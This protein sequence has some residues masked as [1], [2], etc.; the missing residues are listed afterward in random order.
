[1][2]SFYVVGL[3]AAAL[4]IHGCKP[5]PQ[6]PAPVAPSQP[7]LPA[8]S[9]TPADTNYHAYLDFHFAG[10]ASLATNQH[11][12][13]L[14]AIAALPAVQAQGKQALDKFAANAPRLIGWQGKGT[15]DS[16]RLRPLLDDFLQYGGSFRWDQAPGEPPSWSVGVTLPTERAETWKKNLAAW[17]APGNPAAIKSLAPHNV[18]GWETTSETG[19]FRF[20]QRENSVALWFGRGAKESLEVLLAPLGKISRELPSDAWLDCRANAGGVARLNHFTRGLVS[21][22]I[23]SSTGTKPNME[24]VASTASPALELKLSCKDDH[25]RTHVSLKYGQPLD[26]GVSPWQIPTRT[27]QDPLLSFTAMQ[28]ASSHLQ[29]LFPWLGPQDFLPLAG[30]G[31]E[32]AQVF[33]WGQSDVPFQTYVAVSL[34]DTTNALMKLG[35]ELE[36]RWAETLKARSLGKLQRDEK[37]GQINWQG[38]L[39][40][41]V[42]FLAPA[43]DA[44][45]A[46][47]GIFPMSPAPKPMPPELAAQVTGRTNVVYYSWEITQGRLMQWKLLGQFLT[48]LKPVPV[49]APG[50]P[51]VPMPP[52]MPGMA[53]S[54]GA[55][56][57]DELGKELGNSVTEVTLASPTELMLTRKSHS[58]FTALEWL[59]ISHWLGGAEFPLLKMAGTNAPPAK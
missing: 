36:Q 45:Y 9:A 11:A 34:P 7:A 53:S 28:P 50:V 24:A 32:P 27:I 8:A 5:E 25:V 14:R 47:A 37:S 39:P 15:P 21:D 55:A 54:A 26:A 12:A 4:L 43:P 42:P 52:P 59:L 22:W 57:L 30:L 51:G 17:L 19:N 46:V 41:I 16:A 35:G 33:A 10:T 23:E 31:K 58:G 6:P 18:D 3:A 48:M 49:P 2:R 20:V 13:K 1:M 29:R 44:G 38:G 40:M 56:W